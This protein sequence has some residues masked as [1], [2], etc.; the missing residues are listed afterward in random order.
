LLNNGFAP[1]CYLSAD[2]TKPYTNTLALIYLLT[3]ILFYR[4]IPDF[5]NS[6]NNNSKN[7]NMGWGL[8]FSG[9]SAAS[10]LFNAI[11]E[12]HANRK[13][14][15][16]LNLIKD[17][18]KNLKKTLQQVKI[19]NEEILLKLDE[20]PEKI[21]QIVEEI[22]Q[23]ALLEERYSDLD[24]VRENFLTLRRWKRVSIRSQEWQRYSSSMNYVFDHENRISRLFELIN[25]CEFALCIT[26]NRAKS[27][28]ILRL[29]QK[30]ESISLLVDE[31]KE[32]IESNLD[33]LKIDLDKTKYILSHNLSPDLSD[34][35]NLNFK[36]QPNKT[37][38]E[39]YHVQECEWRRRSGGPR[40]ERD[41]MYRYC[42]NIAKTRQVPDVTFH[43]ARDKH[44]AKI[45]SEIS[46]IRI[47]ISQFAE[48]N[49][50]LKALG[51]YRNRISFK[52]FDEINQ[53]DKALI[54][55]DNPDSEAQISKNE[56][57]IKEITEL[58]EFENENDFNKI[59]YWSENKSFNGI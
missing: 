12:S 42:E 17:Y 7:I 38:T 2:A 13:I 32:S 11:D 55:I 44:I 58:F 16:D 28:V 10:G 18:L 35:N 19:Q 29:D 52:S 37:K 30:I 6:N 34:F 8:V 25:I 5:Y 53:N 1:I 9:V 45:N 49:A 41:D 54:L 51:N 47:Q 46:K 43:N 22:V 21:R 36:K 33:K 14:R 26:R 4:I 48:L 20:L 31:F 40:G 59:E 50:V 56:I 39:R 23:T 15:A 3:G 57:D 24:D 27:L